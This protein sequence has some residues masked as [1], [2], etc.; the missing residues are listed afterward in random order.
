[1]FTFLKIGSILKL[2]LKQGIYVVNGIC[3]IISSDRFILPPPKSV[4]DTK[5]EKES[6][7]THDCNDWNLQVDLSA[8]PLKPP[9]QG[10][11]SVSVPEVGGD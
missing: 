4:T 3:D 2:C 8:H 10:E 6:G 7:V 5:H 11:G 1:M 9:A